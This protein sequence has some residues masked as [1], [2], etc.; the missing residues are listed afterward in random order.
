LIPLKSSEREE[1]TNGREKGENNLM[2]REVQVVADESRRAEGRKVARVRSN[3]MKG[4]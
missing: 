4:G 2:R 1:G 3:E